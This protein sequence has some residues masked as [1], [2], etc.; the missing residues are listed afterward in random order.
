MNK[1]EWKINESIYVPTTS[2][3]YE[4]QP[5]VQYYSI[6]DELI[7][8]QWSLQAGNLTAGNGD[9]DGRDVPTAPADRAG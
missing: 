6:N 8:A 1:N 9:P 3:S 4:W 7:G 5:T 2:S